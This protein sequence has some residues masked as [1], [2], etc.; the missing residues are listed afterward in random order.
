MLRTSKTRKVVLSDEI[1]NEKTN[2]NVLLL[3]RKLNRVL[4]SAE[5]ASLF[6]G[7]TNI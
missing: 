1:Y 3:C 7:L 4:T 2:E 5:K 6:I